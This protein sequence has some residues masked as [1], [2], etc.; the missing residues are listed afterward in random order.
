MKYIIVGLLMFMLGMT[1]NKYST[2]YRISCDTT[3]YG[4]MWGTA[5]TAIQEENGF[6]CLGTNQ[7][8]M[9]EE[10]A[11]MKAQVIA[12]E[13]LPS[14]VYNFMHKHKMFDVFKD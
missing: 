2:V 13:L 4:W 11:Y 9:R 1:V 3:K 7:V 12:L 14:S 6:Q 8:I 5:S 10:S